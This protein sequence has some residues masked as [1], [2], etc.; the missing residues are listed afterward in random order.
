M[1]SIHFIGQ[2]MS[3]SEFEFVIAPRLEQDV[4]E[5]YQRICFAPIPE[6]VH[7]EDHQKNIDQEFKRKLS[8]YFSGWRRMMMA[9][10]QEH[11]YFSFWLDKF[12]Q[13]YCSVL[14][15]ERINFFEVTA[16][17][18][19][20]FYTDKIVKKLRILFESNSLTEEMHKQNERYEKRIEKLRE[21][22]RNT[23]QIYPDA[24]DLKLELSLNDV[25]NEIIDI[26]QLSQYLSNFQN[27]LATVFWYRTQVV[28]RFYRIVRDAVQQRYMIHFYLTF[29][30]SLY[31]GPLGYCHDIEQHWLS[32]TKYMGTCMCPEVNQQ[33]TRL[34]AEQAL[35]IDRILQEE[36]LCPLGALNEMPENQT[37]Q[38]GLATR[39]CIYPKGFEWFRG[40]P[41]RG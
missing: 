34:D 13:A 2:H 1:K 22:Y 6:G 40:A 29:N 38:N 23:S 8:G 28:Y 4:L 24:A 12:F 26:R 16:Q 21:S 30:Q 17:R 7:Y 5:Y 32:A 18:S 14:G 35:R 39:I 25:C 27:S 11:L 10:M 33:H 19:A 41:V 36:A 3:H 20:G 37:G 9:C 31:S 15:Q